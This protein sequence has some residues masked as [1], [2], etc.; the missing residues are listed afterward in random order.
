MM[1]LEVQYLHFFFFLAMHIQ[2]N[3]RHCLAS[4][5]FQLSDS[6]EK[7]RYGSDREAEGWP[8]PIDAHQRF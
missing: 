6:S 7:V 8:A 3:P 2:G 1:V 5:P 4:P